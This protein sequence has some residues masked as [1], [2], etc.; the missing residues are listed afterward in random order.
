MFIGIGITIHGAG[1]PPTTAPRIALSGTTIGEDAS[2]GDLIGT[3]SVANSPEGVTWTF[4]TDT[5]TDA[6]VDLDGVDTSL[7]EVAGALDFETKPSLTL[8]V[9]ATP[10]VGVPITRTFAIQVTDVVED[11]VPD[12][13]EAGDWSIAP[14]DEEADVTIDSLPADGGDTITDV[15]YRVDGGSPESCGSTSSCTVSGLVN[16]VEVGVQLRAVNGVGAG[17]WGDTKQVTPVGAPA[18]A[19]IIETGDYLLLESSDR[20][21]LEAI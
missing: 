19:F 20:I 2:I 11:T 13:F 5:G 3:L 7:V 15:E 12:A 4:A 14:G 18:S 6:E 1:R 21:L 9:I 17:A 16:G 8:R 10:S